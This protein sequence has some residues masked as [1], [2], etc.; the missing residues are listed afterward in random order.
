[1]K[2]YLSVIALLL[3]MSAS[4]NSGN[5]PI[6]PHPWNTVAGFTDDPPNLAEIVGTYKLTGMGYATVIYDEG[7]P[8]KSWTHNYNFNIRVYESHVKWHHGDEVDDVVYDNG[9]LYLHEERVKNYTG[10]LYG[11]T[12]ITETWDYSLEIDPDIEEGV[13]GVF[14]G[15]KVFSHEFEFGEN[16]TT[17]V[18]IAGDITKKPE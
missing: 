1:M 13:V 7:S 4:C 8:D 10:D 12:C 11:V 14:Y 18:E 2:K 3:L 9:I 5:G 6:N 15:T 16:Y 17:T